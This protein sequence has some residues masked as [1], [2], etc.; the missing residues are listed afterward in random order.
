[1][2]E[3]AM[4]KQYQLPAAFATKWVEALRSGEYNQGQSR[5]KAGV[6]SYC[7]LGVACVM[8]G[9][10]KR[11]LSTYGYIPKL[12]K[13][14]VPKELKGQASERGI[15]KALTTMNDAG[16]SFPEIADWITE[17]VEFV[18]SEVSHD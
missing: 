11:Q 18:E 2:Q 14:N 5:L 15:V 12:S 8:Q 4:S 17:N 10:T 9:A 6:N 13:I 7:C 3:V 16:K 1:M